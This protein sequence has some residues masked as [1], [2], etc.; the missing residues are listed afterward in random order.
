MKILLI[1]DEVG[2]SSDEA[3]HEATELIMKTWTDIAEG[4]GGHCAVIL[5]YV[6]TS[7]QFQI[8]WEVL[9]K[10]RSFWE[11]WANERKNHIDG[12]SKVPLPLI[13][14]DHY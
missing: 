6:I 11:K 2:F 1:D 7:N 4:R 3:S 14:I 5:H 10:G 8:L 13:L 12:S 9:L